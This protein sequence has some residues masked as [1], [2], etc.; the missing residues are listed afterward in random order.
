M[1][2]DPFDLAEVLDEII[3]L[4]TTRPRG[5][6]EFTI[7]EFTRRAGLTPA[8]ALR[9]LE[10]LRAA[11]TLTRREAIV[12]QRKCWLYSKPEV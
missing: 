5:P 7:S 1:M 10:S 8:T 9:R 2:D 3:A 6:G 4:T 12:D 11:G